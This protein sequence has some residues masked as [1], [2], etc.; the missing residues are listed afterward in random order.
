MQLLRSTLEKLTE[1]I[2]GK[3]DDIETNE[4][5]IHS[6]RTMIK[7]PTLHTALRGEEV[8]SALVYCVN[9]IETSLVN[10]PLDSIAG[11]LKTEVKGF[12][13]FSQFDRI[14]QGDENV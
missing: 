13:G 14:Q 7:N 6:I 3:A 5:I 1:V 9:K 4:N 12:L 2:E 10:G 11:D 8:R